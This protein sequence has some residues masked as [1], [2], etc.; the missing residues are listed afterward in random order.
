MR[1]RV[2]RAARPAS[3]HWVA[4]V[5]AVGTLLAGAAAV[6]GMFLG[7]GREDD[8]GKS[9]SD[10]AKLPAPASTPTP[11]STPARG[12]VEIGSTFRAVAEDSIGN[13]DRSFA[14]FR[15][16]HGS[17]ERFSVNL[18]KEW[19][20]VK[21]GRWKDGGSG[22]FVAVATNVDGLYDD[23]TTPGF[24]VGVTGGPSTKSDD[25]LKKLAR[26]RNGVCSRG[27]TGHFD[28]GGFSGSYYIWL[29]CGKTNMAIADLALE[30]RMTGAF[31]HVMS[32][33]SSRR[34]LEAAQRAL[35]SLDLPPATCE[36]LDDGYMSPLSETPRVPQPLRK[37]C[38]ASKPSGDR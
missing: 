6:I 22:R 28:G 24:F 31:V 15:E 34:D 12:F 4:V 8:S 16:V 13:A 17:D 18:P 20:E 23:Y 3:G 7:A 35:S 5:T 2:P 14:G 33:V 36:E 10:A 30:S 26:Q 25:F 11:T 37:E 9:K 21:K 19:D 38:Q 32:R 27:E 29:K 1:S